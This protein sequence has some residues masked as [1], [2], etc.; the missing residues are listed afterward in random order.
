MTGGVRSARTG[1]LRR[2]DVFYLLESW[3]LNGAKW[4]SVV[5]VLESVGYGPSRGD[6]EMSGVITLVVERVWYLLLAWVP[7]HWQCLNNS[8]GDNRQRAGSLGGVGN[9]RKQGGRR[10]KGPGENGVLGWG[11]WCSQR[12]QMSQ[13]KQ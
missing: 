10:P 11:G 2:S 9:P 4:V 8:Q 1:I 5:V 12:K 6:I 13:K 3:L 7:V